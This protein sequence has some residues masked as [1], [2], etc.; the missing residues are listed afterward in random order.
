[1]WEKQSPKSRGGAGRRELAWL[2]K[3]DPAAAIEDVVQEK[4]MKRD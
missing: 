3:T 1:M 4:K 2:V